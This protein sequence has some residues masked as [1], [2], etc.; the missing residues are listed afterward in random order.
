MNKV[1]LLT[2]IVFLFSGCEKAIDFDLGEAETKLVV[3][4]TIENGQPPMVMLSRSQSFFSTFSPE[5]L[6]QSF[7]QGAEVYISNGTLT[8][9]LKEYAVPLAGGFFLRYYSNDDTQ[10]GTA[11][12][13]RLKE[14]TASVL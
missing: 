6:A 9:R 10:A 2:L 1:L 7:V 11:F 13:V 12:V 8:H 5:L 3:E 14:A 4:A